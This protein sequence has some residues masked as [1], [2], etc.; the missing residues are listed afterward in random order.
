MGAKSNLIRN[1][2]EKWPDLPNRT[3]ALK[4]YRENPGTFDNEE[5]ARGA[6][7]YV[8]GL[9]GSRNRKMSGAKEHFTPEALDKLNLESIAEGINERV[10]NFIVPSQI[11]NTLLICDV[12]IPYHDA[13]AL[14]SA[15]RY[16]KEKKVDSVLINGDW[17]DFSPISRFTDCPY[18]KL[19]LQED[20]DEAVRYLHILRNE[21]PKAIIYFKHGNHEDWLE[22]YL[23]RKAPELLGLS[24]FNLS[25]IFKFKELS[26][27]EI[28]SYQMIKYG[29]LNIIHGH[30]LK[31]SVRSVNPARTLYLKTKTN[32]LVGHHHVSS[33]NTENDLSENVTTCW[34]IGCLS[35]LK[36]KYA[37][38]D[39]K[40][41]HGFAHITKDPKGQFTVMSK[42][43]IK[44]QIV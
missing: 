22:K 43:I 44:G 39:S 35:Q 20:I 33:E 19:R 14:K 17:I 1:Y 27:V 18:T 3:L 28:G 37:G 29:K 21:F 4:I 7:R 34:S 38:M 8:K 13:S 16:G 5:N 9:H 6:V 32:C 31:Q 40:Y 26:I 2:V 41:N 15:L 23:Q 10:P 25:T 42:R 36:P 11:K 12:H 30:E 24:I